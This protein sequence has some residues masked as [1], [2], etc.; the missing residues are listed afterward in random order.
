MK[1]ISKSQLSEYTRCENYDISTLA[2]RIQQTIIAKQGDKTNEDAQA[3]TK[4]Q[5]Q[6]TYREIKTLNYKLMRVVA[7]RED[8]SFHQII[9]LKKPSDIEALEGSP[10]YFKI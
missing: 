6:K 7:A 4:E 5:L 1:S 2:E 9:T 10:M 3:N 8:T